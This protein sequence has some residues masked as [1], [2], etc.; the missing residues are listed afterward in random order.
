M[1]PLQSGAQ[2]DFDAAL[3][4]PGARIEGSSRLAA[5][6]E[7]NAFDGDKTTFWQPPYSGESWLVRTF[8]VPLDIDRLEFDASGVSK[9]SIEI[10]DSTSMVYRPITSTVAVVSGSVSREFFPAVR[11]L[12]VRI[13]FTG[14]WP[15][16]TSLRLY[17][18]TSQEE[19]TRRRT[20][21]RVKT[22][23]VACIMSSHWWARADREQTAAALLD[24]KWPW[25]RFASSDVSA[26]VSRI[27]DFDILILG[28]F[29]TIPV[30]YAPAFKA[31]VENGGTIIALDANT[32]GRYEWFGSLGPD[33]AVKP[34]RYAAE[35]SPACKVKIGTTKEARL[36]W[37]SDPQASVMSNGTHFVTYGD[38][39]QVVGLSTEDYP[40]IMTT[41]IG[42]GSIIATTLRADNMPIEP[43]L[44]RFARNKTSENSETKNKTPL[45]KANKKQ[46]LVNGKPFFPIGL[47][48]AP[49]EMLPELHKYGFNTVIHEFQPNTDFLDASLRSKLMVCPIIWNSVEYVKKNLNH[50]A[51]LAWYMSDEP[52]GRNAEDPQEITD[53]CKNIRKL[54]KKRPTVVADNYPD[55]HDAAIDIIAPDIYP[56]TY[57]E[58]TGTSWSMWEVARKFGLLRND[59]MFASKSTWC[60]MQ[61]FGGFGPFGMPTVKQERAMVYGSICLGATGILFYSWTE[62]GRS[63]WNLGQEKDLWPGIKQIAKELD[64]LSPAL[65]STS[66]TTGV[67]LKS[68][69]EEILWTHRYHN[70][71]DYV[72]A[73]NWGQNNLDA[74]L[75]FSDKRNGLAFDLFGK[76]RIRVESGIG[77]FH[78]APLE[79]V[80]FKMRKP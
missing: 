39:W 31:F 19:Q 45:L 4:A 29:H 66:H 71:F 52:G 34:V 3:N 14:T 56:I 36:I 12:S 23:S 20:E 76:K 17:S 5:S 37:P 80:C 16:V 13:K 40:V 22:P 61:A 54:D 30:E 51:I 67:S 41:K 38:A 59:P 50:P 9:Y 27:T 68:V 6:V 74:N 46:L 7:T 42:K 60:V 49:I 78:L 57:C 43:V 10:A 32:T 8:E 65:L 58:E 15:Q 69:S 53:A 11:A 73:C 70:G 72:I 77:T 35:G 55:A 63:G 28:S 48:R 64:Q 47:Y 21:M 44:S 25:A 26:L 1:A 33:Y 75:A 18:R 24:L 2:T 79:V 62:P